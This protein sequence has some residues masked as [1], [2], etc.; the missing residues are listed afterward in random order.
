MLF[1]C[2]K[3]KTSSP[4]SV[5]M[6]G[7]GLETVMVWKCSFPTGIFGFHLVASILESSGNLREWC[8]LGENEPM[9]QMF[10]VLSPSPPFP[11]L[12]W[13]VVLPLA[14][15]CC[16]HHIPPKHSRINRWGQTALN[17]KRKWTFPRLSWFCKWFGPSDGEIT[18]ATLNQ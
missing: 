2:F 16:H 18:V 7:E 6:W 5:C 4:F 9:I 14:T 1:F 8:I 13:S 12:S 11:H 17:C 15:H 3:N 10:L